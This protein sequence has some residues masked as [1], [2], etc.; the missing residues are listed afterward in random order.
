MGLLVGM[1]G[2]SNA[3]SASFT[4]L[5]YTGNAMPRMPSERCV[6]NPFRLGYLR[7]AFASLAPFHTLNQTV[8]EQVCENLVVWV[9]ANKRK[10]QPLIVLIPEQT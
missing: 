9:L 8:S 6:R 10:M 2:A 3:H 4:S 1:S 5:G 7:A